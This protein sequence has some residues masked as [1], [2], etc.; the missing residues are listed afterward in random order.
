MGFG[1]FY[2]ALGQTGLGA[3]LSTS[4]LPG[5]DIS[6]S[7]Y[8]SPSESGTAAL[9]AS[10]APLYET[11]G[12]DTLQLWLEGSLSDKGRYAAFSE[13]SIPGA[14]VPV[15]A[16]GLQYSLLVG[17]SGT[18]PEIR[19]VVLLEYYHLS[20]GLEQ[21]QLG[22]VY[23][24]LSSTNPA[25]VGQSSGWFAELARRPGRQGADYLF[26]SL[27][28][29]SLTD[30]GDPVFDRIG[31]S[32]TC[33][34]NLTDLSFFATGGITTAFVKDSE[35]DLTVSWAHGSAAAEFG[36][37]PTALAVTLDVKVFF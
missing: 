2:Y 20:E 36:N 25:V 35:V 1:V 34:V 10:L 11:P 30:T 26:A 28:Q 5:A 7:G 8:W 17:A 14:V 22:A 3:K 16:T 4:A 9:N 31:L 19:T 13:G 32:A 12:W 29:P 33:L 6:L 37:I 23:G 15:T 21:G 27:T 24:A 18:L